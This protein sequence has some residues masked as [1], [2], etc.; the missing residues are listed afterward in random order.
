MS[1]ALQQNISAVN[2][3]PLS[4][5]LG[6]VMRQVDYHCFADLKFNRIDPLYKEL[7]L[8]IAEA[9]LLESDSSVKINGSFVHTQLLKEVFSQ[10]NHE[11]L[12]LVFDNFHN[13][14]VRV[15]N[16]KAYLR[17]A[18]YNA[19]FELESTCTNDFCVSVTD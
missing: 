4:D 19:V 10:L 9:F 17:T 5:M 12:R 13:V 2:R 14:T 6:K 15:Y 8:V 1:N 11:H 18:M 16:K 3:Q 7:C